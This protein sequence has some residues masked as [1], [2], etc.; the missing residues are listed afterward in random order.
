M[1]SLSRRQFLE[2]SM[3]AT[4]AMAAAA[5][6]SPSV[7]AQEAGSKSANDTI[8][9][10]VIGCRIR[11]RVHAKEFGGKPGVE[12]AYVCDPDSQLANELAEAVEK[13]TGKR[14]QAVQDLRRVFDDK[15]VDTVSVAAPNH[16]HALA[17]I[18]AMQAGKDVYVEKPVSHNISEGR[19]MVQ[20]SRK[21]NRICQGG[22]QYRSSGA[23]AQAVEYMRQGK[24]GEVKLARSIV[25]GGRGSIGE[26]GAY[27]VP[28]GVDY[29]LFLGP[30]PM[31]P[32]TRKN[33]H[34][35]WHW[36]WDPQRGALDNQSAHSLHMPRWARG[37]APGALGH[38]LRRPAGI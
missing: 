11:G 12:V 18:W 19:R 9:H 36:V 4:A 14:P 23:N 34:Y 25:Y 7:S 20:V 32:L 13:E 8:R 28:S 17:A 29:N 1:N 31:V 26:P 10:A 3:L 35:D 21:T 30:A 5:T 2:D 22:H 27:E 24:L 37:D 16:W 6:A 15:T 33:L 38:Q